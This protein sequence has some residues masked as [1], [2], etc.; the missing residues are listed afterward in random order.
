MIITLGSAAAM[1]LAD[2]TT[3]VHDGM[4]ISVTSTTA[5]AHAVVAPSGFNATGTTLTLGGAKGDGFQLVA[6]A[7]KWYTKFTRNASIT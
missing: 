1:T 2:P 5:F 6:Y 4:E 3:G 7:G